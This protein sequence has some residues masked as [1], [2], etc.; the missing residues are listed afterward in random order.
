MAG[1]K[2][3][4]ARGPRMI[5]TKVA[6][7]NGERIAVIFREG[8]SCFSSGLDEH[9]MVMFRGGFM[10]KHGESYISFRMLAK[11]Y[12]LKYLLRIGRTNARLK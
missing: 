1:R 11:S 5:L 10:M 4:H 12:T 6:H 2:A 8:Q 7:D 9:I 3:L